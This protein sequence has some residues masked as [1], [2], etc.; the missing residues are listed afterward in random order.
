MSERGQTES[1]HGREWTEMGRDM[2]WWALLVV[3]V[4]G[5]WVKRERRNV[6]GVVGWWS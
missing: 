2:S 1:V 4:K 5:V 6:H 3:G